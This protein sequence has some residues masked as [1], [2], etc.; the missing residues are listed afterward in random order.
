MNA[1]KILWIIPSI[2]QVFFI[3]S[4]FYYKIK[5]Y[6]SISFNSFYLLTINICSLSLFNLSLEKIF[7]GSNEL[8]QNIISMIFFLSYIF[9]IKRILDFLSL[10]NILKDK[11]LKGKEKSKK[12][13]EKANYI[14]EFS[15]IIYLIILASILIYLSNIYKIAKN[16]K[17]I[18][19]II[20]FIMISIF[21]VYKVS[22][23]DMKKKFRKSYLVEIFIFLLLTSNKCLLQVNIPK[24]I[25]FSQRILLYLSEIFYIVLISINCRFF[26]FN[27]IFKQNCLI[28]KKLNSDFSLFLNNELCFHSFIS[29]INKNE[30]DPEIII[31]L[32]LYLDINNYNMEL[33]NE[34]KK[35]KEEKII[36]YIN[37][38]K[39]FIK[40]NNLI[41]TFEKIGNANNDENICGEIFKLI[42]GILNKKFEEFK[43]NK[44]YKKLTGF[45]DLIFY[46]DEFIFTKPYYIELYGNEELELIQ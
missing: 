35:Q 33:S 11:S 19:E 8:F 1:Q 21:L 2:A 42:Y 12:L 41:K 16:K 46:L 43:E 36:N 7:F 20:S 27:H 29:F 9:R 31:I 14:F 44:E 3:I 26:S 15:Y 39:Q 28:N 4:I 34:V 17:Y 32:K 10:A 22:K 45:L 40:N 38:N 18:I 30:K 5:T 25:I 23:A 24:S 6:Y 37:N 13:Y